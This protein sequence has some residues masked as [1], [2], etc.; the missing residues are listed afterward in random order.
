MAPLIAALEEVGG[1]IYEV[2]SAA[3]Q[4]A[5][6]AAI[7]ETSL[8]VAG[9]IKKGVDSLNDEAMSGISYGLETIEDYGGRAIKRSRRHK[10]TR[11]GRQIEQLLDTL[12]PN[13]VMQDDD[14][15]LKDDNEEIFNILA[16]RSV[17]SLEYFPGMPRMRRRKS[18]RRRGKKRKYV[19]KRGVKAMIANDAMF[20]GKDQTFTHMNSN[21]M[22]GAFN[23]FATL[24]MSFLDRTYFTSGSEIR[25]ILGNSSASIPTGGIDQPQIDNFR[26]HI[27]DSFIK[28]LIHNNM[29]EVELFNIW[30]LVSLQD[31][32]A[33]PLTIWS[34]EYNELH[35]LSGDL[36]NNNFAADMLTY[37]TQY[38]QWQK[39]FRI[40]KKFSSTFKPG[41]TKEVTLPF[42]RIRT[43]LADHPVETYLA[44][45]T[46]HLMI[47]IK[48]MPCFRNDGTMNPPPAR[49][50]TMVG[51]AETGADIIVDSKFTIAVSSQRYDMAGTTL[52]YDS[53][54]VAR[55]LNPA[56]NEPLLRQ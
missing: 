43:A 2:G 35:P 38:K 19:T 40:K 46:H 21:F 7:A 55:T 12:A 41:Q 20:V 49:D 44:G 23:V 42:H 31:Q 36:D 47:T 52:E 14:F 16:G 32:S 28:V 50:P 48:G 51:R 5:K 11:S 33:T 22:F 37:P 9:D 34:N 53:I 18:R 54:S 56:T 15:E 17:V 30:W 45:V 3:W 13:D 24:H 8:V 1:L 26:F 39:N 29:P 10:R 4:A 6:I 27:K 25:T